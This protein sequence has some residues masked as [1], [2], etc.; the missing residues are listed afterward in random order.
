MIPK[1]APDLGPAE[2]TDAARELFAAALRSET[3][4]AA[5]SGEPIPGFS[6]RAPFVEA[7]VE[8]A[9]EAAPALVDGRPVPLTRVKLKLWRLAAEVRVE[10]NA[11]TGELMAWRNR[12]ASSVA[13]KKTISPAE[14]LRIATAAVEVP[15]DAAKPDVLACGHAT[16]PAYEVTWFHFVDDGVIVDGDKIAVR[17]S[18]VTGEVASIFRKW[19]RVPSGS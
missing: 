7:T 12:T 8:Q 5:K 6:G 2:R 17:V 14:A 19:R 4:D 10:Q 1:D 3:E 9:T 16:T 11:D 15:P 18:A 13:G